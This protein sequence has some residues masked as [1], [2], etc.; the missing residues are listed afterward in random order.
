MA[1]GLGSGAREAVMAP[2]VGKTAAS[3]EPNLDN[4]DTD[5]AGCCLLR[6]VLNWPYK[7]LGRCPPV[8]VD[9]S[10]VAITLD[11]DD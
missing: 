3:A 7:R 4:Q 10:L 11:M 6:D 2:R 8:S 1:T 5:A 9:R